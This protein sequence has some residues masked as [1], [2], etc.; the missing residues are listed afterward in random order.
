MPKALKSFFD[1]APP[2]RA[3]SGRERHHLHVAV[4]SLLHEASRDVAQ[5]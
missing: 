3:A 2:S 1:D 5:Q 4:A